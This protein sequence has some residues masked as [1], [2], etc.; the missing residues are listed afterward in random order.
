MT[1]QN[2]TDEQLLLMFVK[3]D[4]AA[5]GE[6][7]RRYESP[8]LGLAH[9]L[10][11]GHS[12]VACDAVQEAW[13]RVIRHGTSFNNRSSFKTWLYR[14]TINRCRDLG[15]RQG[16]PQP[17]GPLAMVPADNG[18]PVQGMMTKERND[19]LH[20]AVNTL[21]PPKREVV[22][23]CYHDGMT[24]HQA[25][26]ILEIP[27]GTLKSRLHAALQALRQRLSDEATS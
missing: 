9:G 16:I 5:L 20:S 1:D 18:G 4:S 2:A 8:L 13:M 22:L 14:I 10:L 7:A 24:H 12:S 17:D 15:A 3:G 6:L 21:A 11:G 25:A 27:L 19:A 23:L 26:E